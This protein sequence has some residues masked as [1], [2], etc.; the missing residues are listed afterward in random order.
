MAWPSYE[1]F[2]YSMLVI[3][4]TFF[5]KEK[6]KISI[7]FAFLAATLNITLVFYEIIIV[8]SYLIKKYKNISIK[9]FAKKIYML[10]KENWKT[11]LYFCV[12][13][14]WSAISF[15]GGI[16]E[17][18][19]AN[20]NFEGWTSRFLAYLF[21]LNIGMAPYYGV[22][23]VL[24][25][26]GGIKGFRQKN[27]KFYLIIAAFLLTVLAYS[28]KPHINS[29]ATCISRYNSWSAALL[30]F[31]VIVYINELRI[32]KKELF[33][34]L[35]GGTS[36]LIIVFLYGGWMTERWDYTYFMPPAKL[37]LDKL[38]TL[39]N[40]NDQIFSTRVLHSELISYKD[41]VGPITYVN[42][43]GYITKVLLRKELLEELD[44]YITIGNERLEKIKEKNI[45]NK[46]DYIFI[47]FSEK[48]KI[49]F[50]TG[51]K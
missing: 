20:V 4:L 32:S 46:K 10:L 28:L 14:I 31:A 41:S 50:L 51:E 40:V 1:V 29:G 17:R 12:L 38:P 36:I 47:N 23:M 8:L 3:S 16:L 19:S 27:I 42:S 5:I 44:K 18:T 26:I 13:I 30:I 21:D 11:L 25:V 37:V 24:L 39:Y 22:I 2:I 9:S 48:E 34:Y 43:E 33:Y 6:Y 7:I 45:N 15:W 49:E 35:I